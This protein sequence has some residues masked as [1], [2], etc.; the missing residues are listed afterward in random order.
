M[1][2]LLPAINR[3]LAAM[4]AEPDAAVAAVARR[5]PLINVGKVCAIT[6]PPKGMGE[7]S[8]RGC[9][10]KGCRLAL[11]GCDLSAIE[12]LAAN[13]AARGT[14]AIVSGGNVPDVT[15]GAACRTAA[16]AALARF[17]RIDIL[18]AVVEGTGPIGKSGLETTEE[19]FDQIVDLTLRGVF[20]A[21]L[22][23]AS[24]MVRQGSRLIVAVGRT[25]GIS[26][27][28][29]RLA[30]S[31]CKW[32]LRGTV[33]SFALESGPHGIAVNTVAPGMVDV[34]RFQE[35]VCW[36]LAARLGIAEEEAAQRHAE[37]YAL[38]RI[39]AAEDVAQACLF[40]ASERAARQITGVDLPVDGGWAM[41]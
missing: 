5:A 27:C 2:G 21:I 28:A 22:A 41:L 40:L 19:E 3:G 32:E 12:P 9:A 36:E 31:A 4:L 24:A 34:P 35:K 13:L 39:S 37:D 18:V 23:V 6:G 29:G 16:D 8:M 1:R 7:T 20:N 38:R 15:D 14:E 30:Y 11:W 26:G 25:F 10:A 17:G 33:K